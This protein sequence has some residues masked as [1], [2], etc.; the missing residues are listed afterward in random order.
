MAGENWR[1]L[2]PGQQGAD[3]PGSET[4]LQEIHCQATKRALVQID[5]EDIGCIRRK[6]HPGVTDESADPG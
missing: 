3:T 5:D 4:M 6:L 2:R 1:W